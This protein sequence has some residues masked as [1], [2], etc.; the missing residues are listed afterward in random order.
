[1][2]SSF[3]HKVQPQKMEI[4]LSSKQKIAFSKKTGFGMKGYMHKVGKKVYIHI[5]DKTY[6]VYAKTLENVLSGAKK[7]AAIR[8]YK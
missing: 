4:E 3:I 5:D 7:G 8:G 1:M 6:V 2:L